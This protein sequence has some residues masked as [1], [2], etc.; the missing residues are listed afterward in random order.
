MAKRRL[1]L[2]LLASLLLAAPAW[3]ADTANG[4]LTVAGKKLTLSNVYAY[5]EPGFFDKA[6]TDVVVILSDVPIPA[7][8]AREPFGLEKTVPQFLKLTLNSEGQIISLL[9][10]HKAFKH[11]MS[12]GST[13]FAFVKKV[14]DGKRVSGR[15]YS[16]APQKGFDDEV[17]EF[18]V[19]FDAAVAPKK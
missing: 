4:F 10:R 9:P 14:H 19:T 6:K 5:A 12:G 13:D 17:W 7:A 1:R 2:S 15:A 11:V 18:D 8:A 16:K 3:A